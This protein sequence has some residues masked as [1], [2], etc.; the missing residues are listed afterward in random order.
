MDYR[1]TGWMHAC[2]PSLAY[3]LLTMTY[4]IMEPCMDH[5][6]MNLHCLVDCFMYYNAAKLTGSTDIAINVMIEQ[7]DEV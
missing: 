3:C 6:T 4:A 1:I 5:G 7:H 2:I